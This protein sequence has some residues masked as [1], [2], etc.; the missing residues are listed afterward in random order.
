M[1][2]QEKK[3]YFKKLIKGKIMCKIEKSTADKE[4]TKRLTVKKL[5]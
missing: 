3:L 2:Q 5:E 1:K 4:Y